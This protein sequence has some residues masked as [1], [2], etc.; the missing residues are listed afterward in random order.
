M[1][2]LTENELVIQTPHFGELQVNKDHIFNFENGMLGFEN[3]HNFIIISEDESVPFKWLVSVDQP[4]I[5]FPLLSPWLIDL[6]YSPGNYDVEQLVFFVVI[7]L[8]NENG[9]MTANLRAPVCLNTQT[10]KGE[11]IILPNEKYSTNYVIEEK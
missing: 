3:L 10:L 11:Q 6:D 7:T 8:E 2:K 4:E 9:Q 1:N 5:G